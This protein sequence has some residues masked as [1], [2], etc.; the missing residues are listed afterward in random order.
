MTLQA[1]DPPPGSPDPD[2]GGGQWDDEP[3]T[4]SSFRFEVGT[5][6]RCDDPLPN[7]GRFLRRDP[8]MRVLRV[9]PFSPEITDLAS[10]RET[11]SRG[12]LRGVHP[13]GARRCGG[14]AAGTDQE[15]AGHP[16][17][18][19]GAV[20]GREGRHSGEHGVVSAGGPPGRGPG[21]AGKTLN[22][23]AEGGTRTPTSLRSLDPESSAS[24]NS[25]TSA[26]GCGITNYSKGPRPG[27]RING[28][29]GASARK[30][31]HR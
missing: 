1:A 19:L 14:G 9:P 11:A 17:R 13:E 28:I 18:N 26:T 22:N 27:K 20:D 16:G 24:A 21:D 8:R 2:A 23:G 15:I 6:R 30:R 5:G 12:D 31:S 4:S 25:A 7:G 29:P 10:R 3:A